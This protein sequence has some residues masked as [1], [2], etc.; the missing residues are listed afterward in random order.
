M[1]AFRLRGRASLR[2]MEGEQFD[3]A[4]T[5]VRRPTC[6]S[7]HSAKKGSTSGT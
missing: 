7:H 2:G 1:S 4:A 6:H 3:T 5:Q